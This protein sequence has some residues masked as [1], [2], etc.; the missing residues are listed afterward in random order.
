MIGREFSLVVGKGFIKILA[1]SSELREE[2]RPSIKENWRQF[3]TQ[4]VASEEALRWGLSRQSI[5]QGQN[6]WRTVGVKKVDF[7]G[8]KAF[9]ICGEVFSFGGEGNGT[10]LQ[11]SCLENPRHGGAWWAAIYGVT[12]SQTRLKWL[13]SSI[14]VWKNNLNVFA[15]CLHFW[16]AK[17]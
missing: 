17:S 5:W 10:P 15:W 6:K 2:R 11:C 3:W 14:L 1:Q 16:V 8:P 12:Q 13:S 9:Q 7:L 4:E